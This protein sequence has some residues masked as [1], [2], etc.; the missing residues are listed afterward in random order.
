MMQQVDKLLEQYLEVR[1]SLYILKDDDIPVKAWE[2]KGQ[3][4]VHAD[5][6]NTWGA[7]YKLGDLI[8]AFPSTFI[9]ST[10]QLCIYRDEE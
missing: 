1:A 2:D 6:P 5:I 7:M 3:T 8:L 9:H 10:G 4:H